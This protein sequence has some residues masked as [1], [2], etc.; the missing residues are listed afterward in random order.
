MNKCFTTYEQSQRLLKFDVPDDT[1]DAYYVFGEDETVSD[2][3]LFIIDGETYSEAV[4]KIDE[5]VRK[6]IISPKNVVSE[7]SLWRLIRIIKEC[8]IDDWH[9]QDIMNNILKEDS[10]MMVPVAV[11]GITQLIDKNLIDFSKFNMED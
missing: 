6:E 9:K 7:W 11:I 1:A 5:N 10:R 2:E 3:D 8:G 4:R